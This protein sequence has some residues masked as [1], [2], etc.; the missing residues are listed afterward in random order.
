[1]PQMEPNRRAFLHEMGLGFGG[2]ALASMLNQDAQAAGVAPDRGP[3]FAP[4]AKSVIWLFMIGG[5]SHSR[6]ASFEM[7]RRIKAAQPGTTVVFGG[8]HAAFTANDTL[9]EIPDI[10]LVV[11]GEGEYT[12]LELAEWKAEGGDVDRLRDLA[13]I[14][15]RSNGDVIRKINGKTIKNSE[16][17]QRLYEELQEENPAPVF[18]ELIRSGH[19]YY[20]VIK[21]KPTL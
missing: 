11:H 18:I 3:H 14:S 12:C 10:D 2:W 7:A 19:P 17:L 1:M 4:K 8:P 15:Y 21:Q 20:A 9:T 6:F 13:G 5:T 16:D